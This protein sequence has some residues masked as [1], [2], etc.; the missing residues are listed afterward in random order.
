MS[1]LL[2]EPKRRRII[3][4]LL[5]LICGVLTFFPEKYRAAVTLAPSDPSTLGLGGALSQLG[6]A[7]SV[8]GNQAAV[9]VTAKVAQSVIVRQS[10][11]DKMNLIKREGFKSPVDAFRWLDRKVE[12]RSL[13]GGMV[14]MET[15]QPD[16]EFAR[17]LIT[18]Y[19]NATRDHLAEINRQQTG[20]KRHV[21]ERLVVEA[22]DR[23]DRAQA[24]YD[25][26]RLR[27][28]YSDPRTAIEAIGE[29]IPALQAAIK[30]KEVQLNAA[31][32]FATEDN[33]SVL[34][35][36]AE[37]DA[38][39]TQLKTQQAL[40]PQEENSVGR[41][42]QESTKGKRLEREL[43]IAQSLYEGYNRYLQGTAVEDMTS[44][45]NMRVIEQ[46]FVDTAR[47]I[48]ISFLLLGIL[49]A[50]TL[51]ALEFYHLRPPLER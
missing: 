48:N 47:Q 7:S 41:V 8:F 26:F 51:T 9:D 20:Y 28:R 18:A 38:L 14:Q 35:I 29:R 40:N 17:A 13:R 42:V 30:A 12:V 3:F 6:A 31:R 16:P 24:A 46:P 11:I 5:I 1:N 36:K 50:L 33:M 2:G 25:S 4:G 21:L 44:S 39:R 49:L 37:L 34:Q 32:K 23:L 19:A 45:A 10:V 15:E 22:N 27:T 43:F